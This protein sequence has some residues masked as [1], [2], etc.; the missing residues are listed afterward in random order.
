MSKPLRVLLVED[1]ERDAALLLLYL[2]RGGYKPAVERVE[3]A[4]DMQA[5]LEASEWDVIIS[6]ANL[7]NFSARAALEVLHA[8]GRKVP[9]IV[10]SGGVAEHVVEGFMSAGATEYVLKDHMPDVVGVI[11]RAMGASAS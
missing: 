4:A 10:L 8:S 7:P 6:D 11:G 5:R 2:R 3:T 1:S 9:F